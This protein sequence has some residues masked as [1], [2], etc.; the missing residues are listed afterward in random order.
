MGHLGVPSS[1]GV[2]ALIL[3]VLVALLPYL[4][5]Q[6]FGS[7]AL[8]ALGPSVQLGL[9]WAGPALLV[10]VLALFFPV[11]PAL[12]SG[13]PSDDDVKRWASEHGFS[14]PYDLGVRNY[15]QCLRDLGYRRIRKARTA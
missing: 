11:W 5:G 13:M 4:S 2:L 12:K 3:A 9:M 8:P 10:L 1:I 15:E 7:L 14:N 6:D